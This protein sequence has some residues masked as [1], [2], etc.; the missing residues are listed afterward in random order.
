MTIFII[1]IGILLLGIS[2]YFLYQK[3]EAFQTTFDE[4]ELDR[5]LRLYRLTQTSELQFVLFGGFILLLLL[6]SGLFLYQQQQQQ[7]LRTRITAQQ[8][9]I[10]AQQLQLD[11]VIIPKEELTTYTKDTW[12]TLS[13]PW[14]ALLLVDNQEKLADYESQIAEALTPYLGDTDVRIFVDAKEKNYTLS[15]YSRLMDEENYQTVQAN[16]EQLAADA[17]QIKP[18]MMLDFTMN[19]QK[20][21]HRVKDYMIFVREKQGEPLKKI[22]N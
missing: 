10:E 5:K 15:L 2:G 22:M 7:E 9:R 1:V 3:I 18:L 4:P 11:K 6:F 12:Q 17:D 13:I 19:H 14:E 20:E 16:F 8:Q 21:N